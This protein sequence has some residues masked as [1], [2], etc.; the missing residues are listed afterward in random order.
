MTR[1]S[2]LGEMGAK[3]RMLAY[4]CGFKSN[5]EASCLLGQCFKLSGRRFLIVIEFKYAAY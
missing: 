3:G 4:I 5:V 2:R 1:L